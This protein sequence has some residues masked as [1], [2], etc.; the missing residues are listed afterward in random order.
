MK[1]FGNV[2]L[3]SA[4]IAATAGAQ[5][6]LVR[7]DINGIRGT[8][9][10]LLD[11]TN[12]ELVSTTVSLQALHD[13]SR[14]NDIE[15][16]MQVVNVSVPGQT[17]LN[18]VSATQIPEIFQM[19]N[20]RL[21]RSDTWEVFYTPGSVAG[22]FVTAEALTSYGPLGPMGT[23]LLGPTFLPIAFGTTNAAG[24]LQVDFQ[25]PNNPSFI[26]ADLTGQALILDP[27]GNLLISNPDCKTVQSR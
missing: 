24:R 16:E 11:C 3:A 23:W 25:P 7:G 18:V 27:T 15:F 2:L 1:T 21:G 14:R 26:G 13:L 10:F 12:I 22:M 6:Q 19:G 17:V 9:R 4:L 20:L 5:T 8:N